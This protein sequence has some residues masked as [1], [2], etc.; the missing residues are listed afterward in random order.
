MVAC[1]SSGAPGAKQI[2]IAYIDQARLP[3]VIGG[4]GIDAVGA[5]EH[6][7]RNAPCYV[8][9]AIGYIIVLPGDTLGRGGVSI[10]HGNVASLKAYDIHAMV[11]AQ[12]AATVRISSVNI[13]FPNNR[14]KPANVFV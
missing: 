6:L 11:I 5:G 2:L 13:I 12:I 3:L 7:F 4:N 9:I 1:A 8:I 10:P 14:R